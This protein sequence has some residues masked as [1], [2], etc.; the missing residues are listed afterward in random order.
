M[1]RVA[2][3]MRRMVLTLT[4][5]LVLSVLGVL[6]TPLGRAQVLLNIGGLE[7]HQALALGPQS[8]GRS[9]ALADA[10]NI[11]GLAQAQDSSHPAVLRELARV[12][13]TRFDDGGALDAVRQA[14]ESGR[15]DA[16]DML[17]IAH[18]YRD[19]GFAEQGYAWAAR[20]YATWGRPPED[21]VMQVYAQSTLAILDDDRARLLA[22]QAETAMRWR[23]FGDARTLFQQALSF[24][25]DSPYLQDRLGA[26][27]RAVDKYGT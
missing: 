16:F 6:A 21:A 20:A 17:Q 24:E 22:D 12:R 9:A 18:L 1:L 3:G 27:Q 25:P 14:T 15:L 8:A 26:A 4:T 2:R 19:L 7:L 5:V 13:S 10:E 23:T 11:L